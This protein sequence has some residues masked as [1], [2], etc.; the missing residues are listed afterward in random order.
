MEAKTVR[1]NLE[2]IRGALA[3]NEE[4][5]DVLLSL[6]KGYE[7]W[8][9][10]NPE[11]S[12]PQMSLPLAEGRTPRPATPG[13][14]SMRGAVLRV[15]REAHGEP[16][17]SKEILRRVT[18]LGAMSNAKNPLGMMD[19]LAYSL[20]KSHPMKKVGPRTWRYY[21]DEDANGNGDGAPM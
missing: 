15:L 3:R 12:A 8:L 1:L 11:A 4:E 5:H 16:L 20:A 17:H 10:L 13:T 21:A 9:R 14:I 6:L 18:A 2:E 19:L 7:G